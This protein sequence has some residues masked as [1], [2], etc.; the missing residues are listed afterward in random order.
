M[1]TY[2]IYND[3][4][5]I[6]LNNSVTNKIITTSMFGDTTNNSNV[7][8]GLKD[9]DNNYI[10]KLS[11][12][13]YKIV[14][15]ENDNCYFITDNTAA[16]HNTAQLIKLTIP[17]LSSNTLLTFKYNGTI[18]FKVNYQKQNKGRIIFLRPDTYA[19]YYN[20]NLSDYLLYMVYEDGGQGISNTTGIPYDAC[21]GLYTFNPN[22]KITIKNIFYYYDFDNNFNISDSY[23]WK[24]LDNI[25]NF[26]FIDG[27]LDIRN[28]SSY[29]D[30][31]LIDLNYL[32]QQRT[33]ER[34]DNI[35]K[36]FDDDLKPLTDGLYILH[37][38]LFRAYDEGDH[39][40]YSAVSEWRSHAY[41]QGAQNKQYGIYYYD[42]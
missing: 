27:T 4:N 8:F 11:D 25:Y 38:V 1:A 5:T 16:D 36:Y 35:S 3:Y 32:S 9:V 40:E 6:T 41:W 30:A 26:T 29:Y 7:Y 20:D 23:T 14:S 13:T 37:A 10:N 15:D 34:I 42:Y 12:N 39:Y 17:S 28:N 24:D 33:G 18:L 31:G 21:N 22:D 19:S 2:K